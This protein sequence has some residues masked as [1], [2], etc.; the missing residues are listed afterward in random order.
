[1]KSKSPHRPQRFDLRRIIFSAVVVLMLM[2]LGI[3]G[4]AETAVKS[5]NLPDSGWFVDMKRFAQSAHAGFTCQDCHGSMVKQG[6]THPD[7][8]NPDFLKTPASERYD[9]SRCSKCHKIVY[10]RY[11][12]GGHAKARQ[13]ETLDKTSQNAE[14]P[15]QMKAP[16]CGACHDSH[17]AR[18]GQSRVT[19]GKHMIGT[20]GRC[21]PEHTASY[22]D[23]IHG[24]TGVHLANPASAFC[25]DCHGA[26]TVVSLK[27]PDDA[28]LLCRRCH[29]KA[30]KGF[31]GF[32]IHAAMDSAP[33][34]GT[35]KG[36]S[37]LWIHR[38]KLAALVL[39][40]LSLVFFFGHGFLWFLREV[41]EKLRKH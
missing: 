27:N 1:L 24:K 31:A 9:Y 35:S 18:S 37:M 33:A 41:H 10:D 29:T 3:P 25:T 38:V 40:V 23:N 5:D 6:S 17:Y 36:P 32:V 30:E 2:L 20:C 8:E 22:L 15:S 14:K 28:L 12:A 19:V 39:V 34:V 13:K 26:H 7:P 21:H 16:A 11:M 4:N